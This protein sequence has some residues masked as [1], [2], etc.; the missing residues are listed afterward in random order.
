MTAPP[1][2]GLVWAFRFTADGTPQP[3]VHDEPFHLD[4]YGWYW[5]HFNLA[6]A[7]AA[8]WQEREKTMRKWRVC[9]SAGTLHAAGGTRR[10]RKTVSA[11]E[12]QIDEIGGLSG[13]HARRMS[14]AFFSRS[15]SQRP[16]GPGGVSVR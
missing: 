6:D 2:E 16:A 5:L 8:Q 15:M 12:P 3:L 14:V 11:P 1:L 4:Q 10:L 13:S 9:W 7:R